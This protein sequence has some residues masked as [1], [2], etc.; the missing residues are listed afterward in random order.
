MDY[1]SATAE[2]AD[3]ENQN[4]FI[5]DIRECTRCPLHLGRQTACPGYF[6]DAP[7]DV[8]FVGMS[9]GDDEDR[10]G[11]PFVGRTGKFLARLIEDAWEHEPL[12][13]GLTN[14][15]RCH[16]P[17]NRPPAGVEVAACYKWMVLEMDMADPKVVVLMGNSAIEWMWP[18]TRIGEV[19]GQTRRVGNCTFVACY[20]PAAVLHRKSK[21]IEESIYASLRLVKELLCPST[22]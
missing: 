13:F 2:E 7:V 12:T 6:D 9:P 19:A 17:D 5:R 10:D 3:P 8:L 1:F 4:L 11:R 22:S 14:I 20:H 21:L 15:V 16:T 18:G